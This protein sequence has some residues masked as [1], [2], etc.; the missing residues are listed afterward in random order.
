LPVPAISEYENLE[1]DKLITEVECW[2][3]LSQLANNIKHQPV[4]D[5]FFIELKKTLWKDFKSLFLECLNYSMETKQL[6]SSRYE[7][8]ITLIPKPGK[9]T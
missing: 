8:V 2:R 1:C 6:C 7:G 9:N 3:T 5:G 4:L